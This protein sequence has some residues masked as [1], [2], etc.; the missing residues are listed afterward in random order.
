MRGEKLH[1]RIRVLTAGGG[2]TLEQA[3]IALA[4]WFDRYVR[5]PQPDGHLAGRT[6]LEVFMEGR[7]PGVD[8]E[9]LNDLMMAMTL[10]HVRRSAIRFN[11]RQ[12]YHPELHGR[13]HQVL[14]R[15]DLQ[16]PSYI[17]VHETSGELI[18][19]AE[20]YEKLHPAAK[21]LGT[22]EDQQRLADHCAEH[23]RQERAASS[24]ASAFLREE[25]LPLHRE[26]M[27]AVGIAPLP[28]VKKGAA[29]APS[30]R[31]LPEKSSISAEQWEEIQASAGQAEVWEPETE[32]ACDLEALE[33]AAADNVVEDAVAL[34][35][36]LEALS[37][38]ERY[39]AI[40]EMEVRGMMVPDRWR[41]FA[42]YFTNTLEYLNN[43]EHYEQQRGM[44][45]VQWQAEAGQTYQSNG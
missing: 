13:T 3:H 41:D 33:Q 40:V 18:G 44:L 27:A 25:F 16:D 32:P 37:E 2:I 10:K 45:A 9:R 12:Y 7:G 1:R 28:I 24:V 4:D 15:Y 19:V 11:G 20:P 38:P 5:R 34:R 31:R 22:A 21:H 8:R 29:A 26:Q 6:P 42:R 23:R 43:T 36:R 17:R 30:P 14:I 35:A 39:M